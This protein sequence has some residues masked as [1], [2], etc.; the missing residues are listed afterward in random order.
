MSQEAAGNAAVLNFQWNALRTGDNVVMHD[1]V[2]AGS[3]LFPGVVTAVSMRKGSNEIGIR[4]TKPDGRNVIVWPSSF[5][6][7]QAAAEDACRRCRSG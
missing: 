3:A 1:D 4:I 2:H 7:H 6:V 5:V